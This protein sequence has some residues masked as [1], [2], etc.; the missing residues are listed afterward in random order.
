MPYDDLHKGYY[1]VDYR[2]LIGLHRMSRSEGGSYS[3]RQNDPDWDVFVG[4]L[5]FML[6][7]TDENQYVRETTPVRRDRLDQG[8]EPGE[9]SLDSAI[10]PRSQTSWHLGA[11]QAYAEPLEEDP[12]VARFRFSE[13][14]GI[15]PWTKGQI[16]LL[17]STTQRD[18]GARCCVGVPGVG[19]V[20]ST[21][22]AGVRKY[23]LSGASTQ[24][25][26]KTVTKLVTNGSRWFAMSSS[27]LE[28]GNL[29]GG[30]EGAT[31]LATISA[32]Y[33][34]LDRL[35]VGATDTLYE[36]TS[37]PPSSLPAAFHTF[38]SGTIVD[39]DSG[40]GGVYVM[41]NDVFTSIYVITANDDGTLNPPRQ[42]TTLPR[43][44][45][46]YFL[47]GY[48]GSFLVIGTSRGIRLADCGTATDLPVGPLT[49]ELAGGC[50][51][52]VGD[53][54]F[55][56]FT[57]GTT[58]VKP[59]PDSSAVPGLYRLDLSKQVLPVSAYGDSAA[60]RYAYATD[61][62]A[63]S[64]SGQAYSVTT[65][66]NTLFFVA[67]S[68]STDSPLWQ[69]DTSTLVDSGW[70]ES[71][72]IA[73]ATA[74]RKTWL[75]MSTDVQGEGSVYITAS[76]GSTYAQVTQTAVTAPYIGD[77]DIDSNAHPDSGWMKHR[78]ILSKGATGGPTCY[79]LGLR[80][81]PNP[82]RTR[83]IRIPLSC[84]N[85]EADRSNNRVGYDT[86]A[87]DRLL[88]L[89]T[90]EERGG[91]I[92]VIDNRT[93]ENIRCQI[94]KVSFLGNRP[95]D[96]NYTNYGGIIMLTLLKV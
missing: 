60:A 8:R 66:E 42:V 58:G 94:E 44:E 61:L 39:I 59:L 14:G 48:L 83:Y 80:A 95:P 50:L 76:T 93:G 70:V 82:K 5:P 45:T 54:D 81:T 52:A 85:N 89:E 17:N 86:F 7:I 21:N 96:R 87:A 34:G 68:S 43:G 20:V 73:F 28:Y 11:G 40:A 30:G 29:A 23:P 36:V 41:V 63:A 72:Q 56:Y 51:D 92:D 75:S 62:Y 25:S 38:L 57:G 90:L 91:L 71:G 2:S 12:E 18:T 15:D 65:Y 22:A 19:V 16:S 37:M 26:T 78:I 64:G 10:W 24:L 9:Q 33:W 6:A 35:W 46:G 32:L 67:G 77:L 27:G 69:E 74:E 55:I 53:G 31:A 49:V 3:R 13:S 84:F 4:P 47:Y 1:G 88:D 79:S